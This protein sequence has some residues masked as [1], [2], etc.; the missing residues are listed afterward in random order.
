MTAATAPQP[1]LI[2]YSAEVEFD[3]RDWLQDGVHA[4]GHPSQY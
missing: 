2:S 3:L 1:S 4:N